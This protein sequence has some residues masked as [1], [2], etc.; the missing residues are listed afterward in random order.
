[1]P[2]HAQVLQIVGRRTAQIEPLFAHCTGMA[3]IDTAIRDLLVC[4]QENCGGV[5]RGLKGTDRTMLWRCAGTARFAAPPLG[6]IPPE[7]RRR[8]PKLLE[9][10]GKGRCGA[11]PLPN[12]PDCCCRLSGVERKRRAGSAAIQ[13]WARRVIQADDMGHGKFERLDAAG[14]WGGENEGERAC[15]FSCPDSAAV[16]DRGPPARHGI[17]DGALSRAVASS[18]LFLGEGDERCLSERQA[19][20]RWRCCR[21]SAQAFGRATGA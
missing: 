13:S 18:G 9:G 14:T 6:G 7:E 2:V 20:S 16:R 4:L 15:D 5:A 17:G 11:C 12:G 10:L 19:G 3:F 1:M 21:Q 8:S